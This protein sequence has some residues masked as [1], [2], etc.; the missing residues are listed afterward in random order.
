M[1]DPGNILDGLG[2]LIKQFQI[3]VDPYALERYKLSIS[4]IADA[5]NAGNQNAARKF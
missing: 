1:P 5:V 2:G 3:E 4:Q